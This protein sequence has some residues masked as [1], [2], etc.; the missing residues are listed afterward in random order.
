MRKL[1]CAISVSATMLLAQDAPKDAP[2]QPAAQDL[3]PLTEAVR[4]YYK[5]AAQQQAAEAA[6]QAARDRVLAA[7]AKIEAAYGCKL[8]LDTNACTPAPAAPKEQK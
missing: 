8:N 4:D 6:A 5:A 7:Q 3:L 1:L 2:K